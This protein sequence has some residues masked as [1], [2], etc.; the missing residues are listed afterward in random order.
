MA[1]SGATARYP[2]RLVVAEYGDGP[3]R[4]SDAR[5]DTGAVARRR[6]AAV[7]AQ[8]L[9]GRNGR[10]D[11]QGGRGLQRC[12]LCPLLDEGR[13]PR[14]RPAGAPR[15]GHGRAL[16]ARPPEQ[17]R[18]PAGRARR[19]PRHPRPRGDRPAR[20]GPARL[21]ARRGA[22]PGARRRTG[23]AG[24]AHGRAHHAGPDRGRADRRRLARGR[25][26]LRPHA[27]PRL[28]ARPD[29]STFRRPIPPTG[30]PSSAASSAPSP[31]RR[32]NDPPRP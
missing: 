1:V 23:R 3:D 28:D 16:P 11:R 5:G 26:P 18:R 27:R 31:R 19:A 10:P 9:R 20:R 8:G 4:G 2:V 14:R 17:R 13:A 32:T 22:G 25:G 24:A 21:A 15:T 12:H 29:A 30:Q 6:G 7:R